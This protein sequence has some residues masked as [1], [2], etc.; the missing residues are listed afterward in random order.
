M[1]ATRL[2]CGAISLSN[3]NHFPPTLG[4]KFAKPV[5]FPPGAS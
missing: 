3:S 4:S 1:T 5:V 2:L